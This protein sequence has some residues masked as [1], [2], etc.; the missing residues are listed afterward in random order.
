MAGLAANDASWAEYLDAFVGSVTHQGSSYSSTA[1]A[2]RI[3]AGLAVAPQFCAKRR[4]DLLYTLFLAAAAFDM[5]AAYGYKPELHHEPVRTAV[6]DATDDLLALWTGVS[7]AEQ[8]VLGR[9]S[10]TCTAARVE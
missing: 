7:P 8:R 4:L 1:P 10:A 5:A 6:G 9:L 3:I 2:L